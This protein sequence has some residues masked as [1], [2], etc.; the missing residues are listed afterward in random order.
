MKE[1]YI[2][3]EVEILSFVPV[4]ETANL[5]TSTWN[6]PGTGETGSPA[7]QEGVET[8]VGPNEG[9]GDE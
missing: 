5:W 9:D 6:W 4:E 8:P 2:A 7:S 3:P 1:F